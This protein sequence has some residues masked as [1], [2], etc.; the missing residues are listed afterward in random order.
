LLRLKASRVQNAPER[1]IIDRDEPQKVELEEEEAEKQAIAFV[2]RLG[3]QS[4]TDTP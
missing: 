1:R 3:P 4:M 2:A